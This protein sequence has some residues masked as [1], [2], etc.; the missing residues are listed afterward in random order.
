M[1]KCHYLLS[2]LVLSL[3][4]AAGH[5]YA[6]DHQGGPNK[7]NM[8]KKRLEMTEKLGL[9]PEQ[10]AQ[11]KE[12]REKGK[13]QVKANFEQMR[14]KREA[15]QEELQKADF[16][17]A[18]VKALQEELKAMHSAMADQ[19]ME[20]ML[21]VR[22]IL[23]PEQFKKFSEMKKNRGHKEGEQGEHGESGEE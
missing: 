12:M 10:Q 23:T 2:A 4:L 22:K 9:T 21:A 14:A 8:E 7:E 6:H 3:S 13:D 16:D 1:K 5:V 18:K 11:L 17:P 19:H 15:M 20:H